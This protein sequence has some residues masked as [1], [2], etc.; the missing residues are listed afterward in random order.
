MRWVKLNGV[1]YPVGDWWVTGN[2]GAAKV[3]LPLRRNWSFTLVVYPS[4]YVVGYVDYGSIVYGYD[5]TYA[6]KG[7]DVFPADDDDE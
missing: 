2:Q 4:T 7:A 3:S 6:E 5:P 1:F